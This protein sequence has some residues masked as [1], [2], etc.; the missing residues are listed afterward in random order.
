MSN[1]RL[2]KKLNS[3]SVNINKTFGK[4]EMGLKVFDLIKINFNK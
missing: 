4:Y 3:M 2:N 1:Y